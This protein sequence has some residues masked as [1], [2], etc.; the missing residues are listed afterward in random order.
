MNTENT[1][2]GAA[3]GAAPA[4]VPTT[5][6]YEG[7]YGYERIEMKYVGGGENRKKK[8]PRDHKKKYKL[9]TQRYV[10]RVLDNPEHKPGLNAIKAIC[11]I[12]LDASSIV[13]GIVRGVVGIVI[14][15]G[16]SRY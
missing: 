4:P 9:L 1:G 3:P 5:E 11:C 8:Y 10:R 6:Y 15:T 2:A 14:P 16:E 7:T 12:P 13:I